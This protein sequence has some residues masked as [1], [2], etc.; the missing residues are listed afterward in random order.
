MHAESA[1]M[2]ANNAAPVN[3]VIFLTHYSSGLQANFY[4][5]NLFA[6]RIKPHG[7]ESFPIR[8]CILR[9]LAIVIFV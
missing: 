4:A 5:L 3:F 8:I 9:I 1:M 6:S 7:A 2:T